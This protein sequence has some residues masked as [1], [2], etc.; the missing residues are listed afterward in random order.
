MSP[1]GG[2]LGWR[3]ISGLSE[4]GYIGGYI[5]GHIG[6][7]IGGYIGNGPGFWVCGGLGLRALW[8]GWAAGEVGL[9]VAF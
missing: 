4:P 5:G 9:I 2:S 8:G 7:Y 3:G 1:G 6:G